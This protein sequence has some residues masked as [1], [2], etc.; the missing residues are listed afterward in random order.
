M[1]PAAAGRRTRMHCRT[2][3]GSVP[4]DKI[5]SALENLKANVAPRLGGLPGFAG[6]YWLADRK[7]GRTLAFTFFDS[8]ESVDASRDA[9]EQIRNKGMAEGGVTFVAAREW[10]VIASTGDK[11]HSTASHARV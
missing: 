1:V 11:I 4:S 5:Q 7:N 8:K 3:E 10:E 9:A 6:A 2:V